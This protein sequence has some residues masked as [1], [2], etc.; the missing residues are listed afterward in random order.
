MS[1]LLD[2]YR[3][4]ERKR[5]IKKK[6]SRL[7]DEINMTFGVEPYPPEEDVIDTTKTTASTISLQYRPVAGSV[8]INNDNFTNYTVD[9]TNMEIDIPDTST[10]DAEIDIDYKRSFTSHL[11]SES[12]GHYKTTLDEIQGQID[13]LQEQ[14]D[15]L[16][17]ATVQE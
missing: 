15:Q 9:Y 11:S 7:K 13:H 16:E 3:D 17:T 5:N 4:L 10:L 6:L 1:N 12:Y 8:S 2:A 14:I